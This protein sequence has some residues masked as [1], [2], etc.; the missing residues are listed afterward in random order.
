M[1][2]DDDE[3]EKTPE[4]YRKVMELNTRGM[5]HLADEARMLGMQR[6][7]LWGYKG[8]VTF[9]TVHFGGKKVTFVNRKELQHAMAEAAMPAPT[10]R[11]VV[12][13]IDLVAAIDRQHE[14]VMSTLNEIL[15]HLTKVRT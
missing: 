9:E 1:K 14:Q 12:T 3:L 10:K 11:K 15:E 6:S 8:R 4:N 5:F 7:T 13:P 2:D